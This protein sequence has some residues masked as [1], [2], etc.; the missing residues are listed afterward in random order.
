MF[1]GAILAT[2]TSRR[3]DQAAEVGL[4]VSSLQTAVTDA[5]EKLKRLYKMVE[6]GLT[7]L[8]ESRL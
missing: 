8:D 4:R 3:A 5:E 7:D 6:D 2:A 1:Q